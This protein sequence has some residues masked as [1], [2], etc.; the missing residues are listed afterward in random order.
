MYILHLVMD[1][2]EAIIYQHY[3]CPG[4]INAFWTEVTN[5][6]TCQRTKW[7]NKKYG[8]LPAKEA[9]E[10]LW[11]KFCVYLIGPYLII[12]NGHTKYKYKSRYYDRL[13]NRMV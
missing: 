5:C 7:S 11:N 13:C 4:I 8:K 9:K 2:T 6:D 3:Y 1:R 10:I 12:R